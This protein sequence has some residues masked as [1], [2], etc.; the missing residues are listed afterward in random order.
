M[1]TKIRQNFHKKKNTDIVYFD[2]AKAFDRVDH[3]LIIEKL[4]E[5]GLDEYLCRWYE[6]FLEGRKFFVKVGNCM[7][8]ESASVPS[9]VIQGSVSGPILFIIFINTVF[10]LADDDVTIQ[11]F[12]D[13][14]KIIGS[15]PLRV[16]S[17]IDKI[18]AW[19]KDNSMEL[20]PE[21]SSVMYFGRK[22]KR[23]NYVANNIIIPHKEHVRD[24]GVIIDN[25][26]TF[27]KNTT[28]IVN[29]A[30]LRSNQILRNFHFSTIKPYAF[31]FKMYVLPILEYCSEVYDPFLTKNLSNNLENPLRQFTRK[32]FNRC[33][34]PFESYEDRLKQINMVSTHTRRSRANIIHLFKALNGFSHQPETFDFISFSTLPRHP[35]RLVLTQ[36]CH[37]SFFSHTVPKWN[38]LSHLIEMNSSVQSF[39]I[40]ING[41]NASLLS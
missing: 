29:I 13:D 2:F 11:A 19:A 15:D 33:N 21:K 26:L 34:M 7:S 20:A 4:R 3:N 31:L 12:A 36:K 8:S 18:C 16:Q 14:L 38:S 25:N 17:V 28:S 39:R 23:A 41:L 9:G 22:N 37:K 32:V 10:E 1:I 6:N 40:L 24:L 35:A 5:F 27:E 30:N